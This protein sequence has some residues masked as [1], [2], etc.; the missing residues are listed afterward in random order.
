[1]SRARVLSILFAAGMVAA[2][3]FDLTVSSI[4]GVFLAGGLAN[5]FAERGV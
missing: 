4:A 1:M 5:Y 3:L 2:S